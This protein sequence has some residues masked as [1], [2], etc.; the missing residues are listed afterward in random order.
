MQT[1][2]PLGDLELAVLDHLWTHGGADVKEVHR[3]LGEP[4]G[5]TLNTVQSAL[6]RL[7]DKGLLE[8]RKESHAYVY[9]PRCGRQAFQRGALQALMDAVAGREPS[10]LVGTFVDLV[11]RAGTDELERLERLVAERLEALRR[12]SE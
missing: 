12:G 10:A 7:H 3:A 9:E 1:P 6:K 5:V 4:R 2:P 8:R 11:E